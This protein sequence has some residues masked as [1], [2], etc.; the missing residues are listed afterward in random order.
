MLREDDIL[1][2]LGDGNVS[3]IGEL[4]SGDESE[5]IFPETELTELL[6]EFESNDGNF[7]NENEYSVV[8]K[9]FET[10]KKCDV[11]WA[12]KPFAQPR[13]HLENL[14]KPIYYPILLRSPL[15]YFSE[16]FNND[17]FEKMAFSQI[18]TQFLNKFRDSNQQI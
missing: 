15:E 18:Y 5:D 8:G 1:A 9:N 6:N 4:D 10:T 16:Y 13:L 14:D 12:R 11:R 2:L 7:E 3:D 17:I